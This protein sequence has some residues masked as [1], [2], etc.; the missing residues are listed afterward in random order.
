MFAPVSH[1]TCALLEARF[2]FYQKKKKLRRKRN[3]HTL[4]KCW[5]KGRQLF[6]VRSFSRTTFC[7]HSMMPQKNGP[8]WRMLSKSGSISMITLSCVFVFAVT[9]DRIF[10]LRFWWAQNGNDVFWV[11]GERYVRECIRWGVRITWS[12]HESRGRRVIGWKTNSEWAILLFLL[13]L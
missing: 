1:F 6:Q 7:G 3:A 5:R 10:W 9:A 8:S 13:R 4:K 12:V 11:Y 2:S